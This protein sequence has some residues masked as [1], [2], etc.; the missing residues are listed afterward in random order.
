MGE[1]EAIDDVLGGF[2]PIGDDHPVAQQTFDAV[3]AALEARANGQV[4][5]TLSEAVSTFEV[6]VIR[7]GDTVVFSTRDPI[8]A[9]QVVDLKQRIAEELPGIRSVILN[10]V[11]VEAI[12]RT[13]E[14]DGG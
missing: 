8:T 9:A 10:A 13:E 12:Y 6:G 1:A 3:K 7:P 5:A 11:T 14:D 4:E 2:Q